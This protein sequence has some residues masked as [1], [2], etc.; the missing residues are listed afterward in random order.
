MTDTPK[1][2]KQQLVEAMA[3]LTDCLAYVTGPTGEVTFISD[4]MRAKIAWHMA[5]AGA[6]SVPGQAIIKRRAKPDRPG[7]FAG[8]VEWVPMDAPDPD[9]ERT[10]SLSAQGELPNLDQ[11]Y[12]AMPWHVRTKIEGDFT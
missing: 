9:P 2:D 6:G 7:Q 8:S 12:N 3:F 1:P 5:R 4:D 11:M 10:A